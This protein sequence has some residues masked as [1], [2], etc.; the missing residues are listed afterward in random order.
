MNEQGSGMK[1]DILI[2]DD[3][4]ENLRLLSQMLSEQGYSVRAVPSGERALESVQA[5][6]PDL[7]LLD[8]R[9]PKMSGYEVCER[10]KAEP[11]T[12]DIPVIFISALS[13]IQDKVQA[14]KVGGVDYITKPFQLEEVLVRT[15]T[16][17]AL[18]KLQKRLQDTNQKL[19][20]EL[21]LAGELQA[22]FMPSK[23]P[24]IAGWQ[25][26]AEIIPAS[27][28]SGDFFDVFPLPDGLLGFLV[29]DVVDKGVSA[30]LF[31]VLSWSLIRTFAAEYPTEPEKVFEEVN[32]RILADT[33][34]RQYVTVFYGVLNPANGE[35]IYSNAGHPPALLFNQSSPGNHRMLTRTGIPLGIFDDTIWEKQI[36]SFSHGDNL[37]VCTDGITEAQNPVGDFFGQARLFEAVQNGS[38]GVAEKMLGDVMTSVERF[39]HLAHQYD[40]IAV[41][42]VQREVSG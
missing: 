25:I 7:I 22:N 14:F 4:P 33:G 26:A 15:Q 27:E 1:L 37:V 19:E 2:V 42:V 35:L 21:L 13:E 6:P 41:V 24:K 34:A 40:D 28:T 5:L 30:A 12:S 32:R 39:T 31:M 38:G 17:L 9:M 20:H 10:L 3:T 29:A 11:A 18:R 36:I 8:I 16:H 23:L